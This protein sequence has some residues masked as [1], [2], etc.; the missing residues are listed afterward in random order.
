MYPTPLDAGYETLV[1]VPYYDFTR[2]GDVYVLFGS[3]CIFFTFFFLAVVWFWWF[4]FC[5][6][7]PGLAWFTLIYG[8][9]NNSLVQNITFQFNVLNHV[10]GSF[11]SP[12]CLFPAS[13][14][15]YTT[16]EIQHY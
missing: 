16:Q 1:A 12:I 2:S 4:D 14:K 15:I 11:S 8:V 10:T 3:A 9:S 5:L 6:S 7:W 13:H